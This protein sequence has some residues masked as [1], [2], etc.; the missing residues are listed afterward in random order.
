MAM[1]PGKDHK[2]VLYVEHSLSSMKLLGGENRMIDMRMT[3]ALPPQRELCD[4]VSLADIAEAVDQCIQQR[5][6]DE[7]PQPETTPS[8]RPRRRLLDE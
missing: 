7:G 8:G 5:L 6:A 2:H 3:I 1:V 4:R